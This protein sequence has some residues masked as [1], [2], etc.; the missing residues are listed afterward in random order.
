MSAM[1][2]V[3]STRDNTINR[4]I[5]IPVMITLFK[6]SKYIKNRL[7]DSL[8]HGK[9]SKSKLTGFFA[10]RQGPILSLVQQKPYQAKPW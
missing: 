6:H 8:G 7:L 3:Q 10:L 1:A 5:K 4:P 2:V 9:W